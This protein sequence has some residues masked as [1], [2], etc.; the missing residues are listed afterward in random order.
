MGSEESQSNDTRSSRKWISK[1][2]CGQYIGAKN[3]N[4][5][6]DS[7]EQIVPLITIENKN[8]DK[9]YVCEHIFPEL[10][11]LCPTTALPDFY[12]VRLLYEPS[13]R[14]VELKS[15]KLYLL[16]Y[17]N[18]EIYHEPLAN[19]I[20]DEFVK[21]VRPNWIFI[22][23]KVNIRGGISTT[24]RRYWDKNH[25]EDIEKAIKGM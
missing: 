19:E 4:G 11:A 23:L 7:N 22:E 8:K 14:L 16:K 12:T 13:E 3:M 5:K 6:K 21:V 25:G 18:I 15:F 1:M 10:T 17:R 9:K 2:V 24:V 20:L